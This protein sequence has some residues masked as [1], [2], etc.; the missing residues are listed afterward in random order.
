[1]LGMKL[2][3]KVGGVPR[4]DQNKWF[5]KEA[6]RHPLVDLARD[7]VRLRRGGTGLQRGAD[8]GSMR[9]V[10]FPRDSEVTNLTRGE[11]AA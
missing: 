3:F 7:H 2:V 4:D 10:P 6:N 1:M 11:P 8:G 5:I 9:S